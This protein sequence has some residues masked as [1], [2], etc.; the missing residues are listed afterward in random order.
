MILQMPLWTNQFS[1]AEFP[2]KKSRPDD[3]GRRW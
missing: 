2:E 3:S 1:A